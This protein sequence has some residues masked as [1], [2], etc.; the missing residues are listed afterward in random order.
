MKPIPI[1][2]SLPLVPLMLLSL[3]PAWSM[4]VQLQPSAD[5][6]APVG[7]EI[8]WNSLVT[9]ALPG[10]VWYRYRVRTPGSA[11]FRIVRDFSSQASLRWVPSL[12]E[13]LYQVEV[14]ARHRESGQTAIAMASYDV[15]SRVTGGGP[16]ITP[17]SNELVFLYSA[18]PCPVESRFRV[19]FTGA[20]GVSQSTSPLLCT[21]D[22]SMN[23]YLAGMRPESAYTVQHSIQA[24]D[25]TLTRGPVLTLRTGALSFTPQITRGLQKAPGRL[26]QGVLLQNR[27]FEYSIAT[28][29]DGNVIW[30]FPQII[31]YL[32][33]P[34]TGGY[35]FALFENQEGGD[36]DQILKQI[37]LAGNTVLE[38][39]AARMNE[40]LDTLGRNHITSFHHEA[41]NLPGG[42]IMVLAGTERMLT[43]VQGP[44]E[45]A[46]IGDMILVLNRDLEIEWAWDAFE[47]LDVSRMAVLDEKCVPRGGGCPV[48]RLASIANDW[49]H[50]NSLDLTP[51]GGILYSARHQDWVIKINYANG[52]GS[53]GVLWRLG[54]DGDFQFLSD[55][56]W[57]WF[58]H[59]HDASII[60]G[61][62]GP[63]LVV[64]DNGN[65]RLVED[66]LAH[67][68]GQVIDLNEASGTAS[69][70]IN[71][72]LGDYSRALGSAQ[73]L[74]NGNF[75]FSSGWMSNNFSQALE[76][77]PSGALVTQVEAETQLYRSFRMRTLYTP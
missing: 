36:E 51:D 41:R 71:A 14:T 47:H 15:T 67:S 44:G 53:G 4:S 20:D 2:V 42:K 32:T 73:L 54:K 5:Q 33:R 37:D 56:P 62:A 55:D 18:P 30:Y 38:T 66:G 52:Q 21:G 68:R 61:P 65:T 49:L 75:H 70:V 9:Q 13:G 24:A 8:V 34:Q 1:A 3:V 58:S 60:D 23:V 7:T 43:D 26:T 64:Y 25:D 10:T 76:F 63:R 27:L 77:D 59:Q 74:R 50:G 46:V 28:D 69:F 39:N 16:V 57:P 12:R 22:G 35:F 40:Q 6:R 19:A 72:D 11:A 29:L 48:L 45:L 17:T 31:Q